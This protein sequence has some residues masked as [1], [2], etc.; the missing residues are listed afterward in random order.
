MVIAI[1]FIFYLILLED[2]Y[3]RHHLDSMVFHT[4]SFP[5]EEDTKYIFHEGNLI[6]STL[7]EIGLGYDNESIYSLIHECVKIQCNF[8]CWSKARSFSF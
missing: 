7:E 5:R 8:K 6:L 2:N 4:S 1:K 3:E